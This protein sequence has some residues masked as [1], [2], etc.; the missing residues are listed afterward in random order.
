[1]FLLKVSSC[2]SKLRNVVSHNFFFI[3]KSQVKSHQ[4]DHWPATYIGKRCEEKTGVQLDNTSL[5]DGKES[6]LA[7]DCMIVP[8]SIQYL[9]TFSKRYY[10][11]SNQPVEEFFVATWKLILLIW[12]LKAAFLINL[13]VSSCRARWARALLYS[14]NNSCTRILNCSI[15]NRLLKWLDIYWEKAPIIGRLFIHPSIQMLP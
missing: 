15:A 6:R 3:T 7:K 4:H 14:C 2:A 5:R 9:T 8:L 1:M 11:P 10:S 12:W 13:W